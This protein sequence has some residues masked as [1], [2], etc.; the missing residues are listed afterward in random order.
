M[1]ITC[2]NTIPSTESTGIP[3]RARAAQWS[4]PIFSP[5]MAQDRFRG[6]RTQ[7]RRARH[8]VARARTTG[9]RVDNGC[10]YHLVFTAGRRKGVWSVHLRLA[11]GGQLLRSCFSFCRL[12]AASQPPP[13]LPLL[14]P[15]PRNGPFLWAARIC[16]PRAHRPTLLPPLKYL[17][18][19]ALLPSTLNR[20]KKTNII[21]FKSKICEKR[22][23]SGSLGGIEMQVHEFISCN[24]YSKLLGDDTKCW[25]FKKYFAEKKEA[26]DNGTSYSLIN[27]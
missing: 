18:P 10:R 27:G 7:G 13:P 9:V 15:R 3:R 2:F 23:P 12:A 4:R 19:F 16:A 20:H 11:R 8:A 24:F 21:K 22:K 6:M 14:P 26:T 25:I 17:P 5:T 1:Y